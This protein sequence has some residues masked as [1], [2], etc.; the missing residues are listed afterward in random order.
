MT[1]SRLSL[2]LV[3]A[4]AA[5][6]I[7]F[8]GANL[9]VASSGD[10]G[11]AGSCASADKAKTASSCAAGYTKTADASGGCPAM[12]AAGTHKACPTSSSGACTQ[13][14]GPKA[15]KTA[16][17]ESIGERE[18]AKVV[19]VGHY[20]CGHCDLGL[21]GGCQPAFQTKDGKNYL[22]VRNNLSKELKAAARESDVEIVTR[23]KKLEG[24][25]YLEV[26]V[27][28]HAS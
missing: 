4:I 11:S 9:L 18:G 25:E 17:V 13:P 28:R 14:C 5:A 26:E 8:A 16:S 22:L 6:G 7:V 20:A 24:A 21:D 3:G 15:A 2:L 19:L 10:D 23:V 1:R 27:V 12:S